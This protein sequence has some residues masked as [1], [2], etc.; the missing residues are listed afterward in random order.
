M[1]KNQNLINL[2][3]WIKKLILKKGKLTK[4]DSLIDKIH[5]GL[6]L[7]N[8]VDSL[9]ILDEA[10]KNIM[11]IF[12]LKN[13]KIGKR[14]IISPF[15]ILSNFSRKSIGIKWLIEASLKKKGSFYQ[16]FIV[17]VMDAFNNKGSVKKRQID[18]NLVVLENKSNLKYRW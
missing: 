2:N 14:V 1:I 7:L 17:E 4:V 13:R 3:F 5:L 16:N 6:I 12:L 9:S 18:L 8:R 15:F 11:P 10:I